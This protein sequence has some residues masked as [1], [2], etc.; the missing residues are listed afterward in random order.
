MDDGL[1]DVKLEKDY[2]PYKAGTTL[3]VD[4]RRAAWLR[5]QA[6]GPLKIATPPA[7]VVVTK[8]PPAEEQEPVKESHG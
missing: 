2:G 8:A 5:A 6:D 1:E 4:P 7:P 3:R